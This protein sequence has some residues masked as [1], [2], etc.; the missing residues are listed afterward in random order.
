MGLVQLQ[1][2]IEGRENR[3]LFGDHNQTLL[4]QQLRALH[5][6]VKYWVGQIA[7]A[8]AR[9]GALCTGLYMDNSP[10]KLALPQ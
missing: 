2:I 4:M 10:C 7:A 8:A 3:L 9:Q 5:I 1:V 6:I